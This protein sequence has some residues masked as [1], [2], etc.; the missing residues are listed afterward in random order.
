MW[1]RLGGNS[2][3]C[4]KGYSIE[5]KKL[6]M[7]WVNHNNWE[8]MI[9]T[10]IPIHKNIDIISSYLKVKSVR[11]LKQGLVAKIDSGR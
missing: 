7:I 10:C 8:Q 11:D 5:Q 6:Q 2:L 1:N 9:F 4:K 3:D